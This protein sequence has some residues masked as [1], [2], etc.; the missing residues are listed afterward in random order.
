MYFGISD[1]AE[2]RFPLIY[3]RLDTATALTTLKYHIRRLMDHSE[4]CD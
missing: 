4:L 3:Q 1:Y 2:F